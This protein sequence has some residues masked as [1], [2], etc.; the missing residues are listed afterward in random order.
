MRKIISMCIVLTMLMSLVV[1]V[2]ASNSFLVDESFSSYSGG[3][4]ISGWSVTA[5]ASN[6]TAFDGP[7]GKAVKFSTSATGEIM[8]KTFTA[9]SVGQILLTADVCID[10]NSSPA[11]YLANATS[12]QRFSVSIQNSEKVGEWTKLNML[13]DMQAKTVQSWFDGEYEKAKVSDVSI[14]SCS[15]LFFA[16]WGTA[17]SDGY[18]IIDNVKVIKI[19]QTF[20]VST[21]AIH[22]SVY[23]VF[24]LDDEKSYSFYY[25]NED[26]GA[27]NI[28]IECTAKDTLGNTIIQK[29]FRQTV[30]SGK[31]YSNKF[32]FDLNHRT[33]GTVT[34]ALSDTTS[35][36]V[37]YKQYKFICMNTNADDKVFSENSGV[38]AHMGQGKSVTAN[39]PLSMA[40]GVSVIRDGVDW[41]RIEKTKGVYEFPA[42]A[43][44]M[45]NSLNENGTQLLYVLSYGNTLYSTNEK[46]IPIATA[47]TTDYDYMDAWL[48]YVTQVVTRYKDKVDYWQVWNEPNIEAFNPSGATAAQYAE[49]LKQSYGIIKNIDPTAK[50]VGGGLAGV[51][52]TDT[53][54]YLRSML[55]A[56][57]GDYM[58]VLD[59]HPYKQSTGPEGY[60]AERLPNIQADLEQ[61]NCDDIEIW[62]GELGW[63][64]GT[65][66]DA[67]TEEKQA[68]Y[69]VR[70]RVMYDNFN[71]KEGKKGKFFWYDFQNDGTTQN[72]SEHNYGMTENNF[73][74]KP[75]YYAYSAFNYIIGNKALKNLTQSSGIYQANY[76]NGTYVFWKG[77]GSASTKIISLEGD[78][79]KIYDMYGDLITTIA[80]TDGSVS[81][82]AQISENPIFVC[83]EKNNEVINKSIDVSSVII[84]QNTI[85]IAGC[86]YKN[87][88]ISVSLWSENAKV[89][90][91]TV[92]NALDYLNG[93]SEVKADSEGNFKITMPVNVKEARNY[94]LILSAKECEQYNRIVTVG[95]ESV[96][97]LKVTKNGVELKSLKDVQPGDKIKVQG[98]YYGDLPGALLIGKV[99]IDKTKF[100]LQS[101]MGFA[102]GKTSEEV[103]FTIGKDGLDSIDIF[104]WDGFTKLTP[105]YEK[106][107]VK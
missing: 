24:S 47:S 78:S 99:Q 79:A 98:N 51:G 37:N 92:R 100:D 55:A 27:R 9:Q 28:T 16:S 82:N 75:V 87:A 93:V 83:V 40:M 18:V 20:S 60:M 58:D 61:Y 64:T 59:V 85:N 52:N 7:T 77:S 103:E 104:L 54:P 74:P 22:S 19:P 42:F 11:V 73:T 43:D 66:S 26:D 31:S 4:S 67:V 95:T 49:L 105:L 6:L 91:L 46:N 97:L 25:E 45:V 14:D 89:E 1:P 38:N 41:W 36:I 70:S 8:T 71:R 69:S 30:F 32:V 29:T 12:S 53:R 76:G 65:A 34:I 56:G 63:Y 44:E 21:D 5:A 80:G 3:N 102:N 13:L 68:A 15:K 90:N 81:Y 94:T 88:D 17:D 106:Q 39:A 48:D 10:T 35:D 57:A 84:D 86:A 96:A 107:T 62:I 2:S 72:Y 50:V 23:D 33:E 101:V